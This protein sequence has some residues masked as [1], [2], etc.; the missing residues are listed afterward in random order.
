MRQRKKG[1]R[2]QVRLSKYKFD[3]DAERDLDREKCRKAFRKRPAAS[4]RRRVNIFLPP[5]RP[6]FSFS[7]YLLTRRSRNRRIA[8]NRAE[9]IQAAPIGRSDR[10]T[11]SPTRGHASVFH[12]LRNALLVIKPTIRPASRSRAAEEAFVIARCRALQR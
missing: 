3:A 10:L 12:Y 5:L 7:Y 9:T 6:S 8:L 11:A 4:P 1:A 2:L